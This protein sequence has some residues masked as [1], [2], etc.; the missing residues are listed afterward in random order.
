MEQILFSHYRIIPG[1]PSLH[2]LVFQISPITITAQKY[3]FVRRWWECKKR[4]WKEWLW[5]KTM[6]SNHS[7][8][9][10]RLIHK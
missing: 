5:D 7:T 8:Y 6:W 10:K 4:N 2:F 3:Q 9:N 1:D